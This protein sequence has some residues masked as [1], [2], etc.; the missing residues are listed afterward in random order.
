MDIRLI[1]TNVG[2]LIGI[3]LNVAIAGWVIARG[4]RKAIS[5]IFVLLNAVLVLFQ[6]GHLLGINTFDSV[7]SREYFMFTLAILFLPALSNHWVFSVL[8]EFK[9]RA[10]EIF[11]LY[12]AALGLFFFYISVP[13][14]YLKISLPKLDYLP[15]YYD[16]GTFLWLFVIFY[17]AAGVHFFYHLLAAYRKGNPVRKNRIMYF[18]T[19]TLFGYVIGSL[20]FFLAF[21]IKV[22]PLWSMFFSLYII[23][24]AYS[25]IQYELMDISIIAKRALVYAGLVVLVSLIITGVSFINLL[26]SERISNFPL[27]LIPL[28]SSF[29]AVAVGALVW[30]RL[31][32]VETLKREFITI[33]THKLRTPLTRIKWSAD[34]LKA[35]I[36]GENAKRS[37]QYIASAGVQMNQLTDMLVNI[38]ETERSDF[39][40]RFGKED[41]RAIVEDEIGRIHAKFEERGLTLQKNFPSEPLFIFGD[42]KRLQFVVEVILN[43]ALTYTPRG[44]LVECV[45]TQEGRFALLSFHDTGIGIGAE[46]IPMMFSKFFRNE[47]AKLADTEG[48]GIGLYL[49]KRIV[50]KHKGKIS[51]ESEG[52]G[53]GSTVKVYLPIL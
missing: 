6:V 24:L 45:V 53:Q 17:V 19:A 27:W 51:I 2:Y 15:N 38:S 47:K 42:A 26:L 52:S 37:L 46:D 11:V 20:A 39:S 18:M 29:V 9:K 44:G 16:A 36:S 41:I 10:K 4:A 5:V 23:P 31:K 48:I 32:E 13:D 14:S 8:G 21:D 7:L 35:E 40:Y 12:A 25:I 30:L 33:I 43:N 34:E 28:I 1:I 22:D 50:L 3:F 49:S